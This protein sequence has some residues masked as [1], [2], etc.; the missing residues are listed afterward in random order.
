MRRIG[1]AVPVLTL[2]VACTSATPPTS[3]PSDVPPAATALP[4]QSPAPNPATAVPS[5]APSAAPPT[6]P[7]LPEAADLEPLPEPVALIEGAPQQQAEALV[8]ALRQATTAE[9]R[10]P[11]VMTMLLASGIPIRNL[12]GS[13]VPFEPAPS[14]PALDA[15]QVH[16]LAALDPSRHARMHMKDLAELFFTDEEPDAGAFSK[17]LSDDLTI[18]AFGADPAGQMWGWLVAA[19]DPRSSILALTAAEQ[20]DMMFNG[21]QL[22]LILQRLAVDLWLESEAAGASAIRLASRRGGGL[23]ARN[24]G[25]QAPAPCA[26]SVTEESIMFGAE[27][28]GSR[29]MSGVL[30]YLENK[31]VSGLGGLGKAGAVADI[32]KFLAP[33]LLLTIDFELSEPPL[34]RTKSTAQDGERRQLAATLRFD[35]GNLQLIN[36]FRLVFASLGFTF[37]LPQDGPLGNGSVSWEPGDGFERVQFYGGDTVHA[38]TDGSG[39]AIIGIEGRRQTVAVAPEAGRINTTA[40]TLLTYRVKEL[41]AGGDL[42]DATMALVDSKGNPGQLILKIALEGIQRAKWSSA[43]FE[44][45]VV[46]WGERWQTEIVIDERSSTGSIYYQ[47]TGVMGVDSEG[48]ITGDGQGIVT[49]IGTL[50]EDIGPD[51][52]S[53]PVDWRID[54]RH[55][56]AFDGYKEGDVLN[57]LLPNATQS[58]VQSGDPGPCGFSAAFHQASAQATLATMIPIKLRAQQGT[59]SIPF[60]NGTT[61]TIRMEPVS[62]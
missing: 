27:E 3:A 40:E 45:P 30:E 52:H 2:L 32:V 6:L 15:W 26:Y 21:L 34:V 43:S 5:A 62:D 42:Y 33:Y 28:S 16:A 41:S 61:L 55:T 47:W 18:A 1:L 11:V 35:T 23:D 19:L 58:F 29:I 20:G 37:S 22:Q 7:P 60:G 39:I 57:L 38:Q 8:A 31:G 46:D 54:G 59:Q 36:C 53:E 24:R 48:L 25:Q 44:F 10:L 51:R 17:A 50:C 4:G 49:I 56:F 13:A 9:A 12:D 14:G